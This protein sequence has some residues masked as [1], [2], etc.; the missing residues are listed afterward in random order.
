LT[1]EILFVE[2]SKL[3]DAEYGIK[4]ALPQYR[5]PGGGEKRSSPEDQGQEKEP[6]D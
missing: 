2:H 3:E 5:S 6:L 1:G 4:T